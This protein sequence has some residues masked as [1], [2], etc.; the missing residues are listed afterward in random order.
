MCRAEPATER[1]SRSFYE[2]ETSLVAREL[3]GARLLGR[4]P[5]GTLF[6]ARIVETEAYLGPHDLASHT[7]RGRTPRNAVMF[8]PPGH[9]YVYLVYGLHF[10]LNFV[11][12]PVG[13]G[14][15][16]LIRAVELEPA[17]GS[18][19]SREARCDGPARLTRTLGINRADNGLD[20]VGGDRLW[21]EAP[22][23][24]VIGVSVGKRVGIA[25]AGEWVDAPLRFWETGN[26]GVSPVGEARVHRAG[27]AVDSK[28]LAP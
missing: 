25:Y 18:P 19:S 13:H 3:L 22:S 16:V 10:C 2:R 28:A 21:V 14:S 11:T 27:R 4:R 7:A 26:P 15:A 24:P 1:L 5:D 8:G 20:V 12:E 6:E 23:R 17:P 9:A